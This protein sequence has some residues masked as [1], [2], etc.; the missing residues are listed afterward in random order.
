ML[1]T[2]R[3]IYGQYIYRYTYIIIHMLYYKDNAVMFK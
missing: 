2:K 3:K 1:A